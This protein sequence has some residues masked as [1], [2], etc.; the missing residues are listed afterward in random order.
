MEHIDDQTKR[1]M[2]EKHHQ[3]TK[4]TKNKVKKSDALKAGYDKE[5]TYGEA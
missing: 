1:R 2:A 4:T 5:T 3:T